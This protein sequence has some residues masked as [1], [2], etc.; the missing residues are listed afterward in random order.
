MVFCFEEVSDY[1]C[2]MKKLFF[3]SLVSSILF[4][5]NDKSSQSNN[6]ISNEDSSIAFFPV[7]SFLKGQ[8]IEL[9]S[10]PVTVL[11]VLTIQN[12]SDSFWVKKEAVHPLLQDFFSE[13]IN[14]RN[15]IG[16]FKESKFNDQSVDAIT[17]TYDPIKPL[18]DSITIKHWDV[19][20]KQQTG[21]VK[22]IYM[23]KQ[24][25]QDADNFAL[26]LT[27]EAGKWAK[28]VTI[29]NK[30][31]GESELIKEEKFIWNFTE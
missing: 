8:L 29:L 25:K 31:K 5:C 26:Q 27:W 17:F 9:D 19:Y 20:I 14:S 16:Y 12:K 2:W 28:I 18:P 6:S 3:V 23:L 22:R 24:V 4:S 15:L 21:K 11:R 1:F 30:P 13:E 7:T 10:L